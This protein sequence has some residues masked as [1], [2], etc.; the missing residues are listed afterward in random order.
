MT[1]GIGP[2]DTDVFLFFVFFPFYPVCC[3]FLYPWLPQETGP[4]LDTD[5]AFKLLRWVP[6]CFMYRYVREKLMN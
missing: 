4:I 1:E 2:S 5:P 3:L 6:G